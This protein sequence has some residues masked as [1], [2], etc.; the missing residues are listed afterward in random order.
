MLL[1]MTGGASAQ[2]AGSNS[3]TIGGVDVDATGPDAIQARQ[4]AIRQAQQKAVKLL[5]ERMVAPEDRA[6]VPPLDPARVDGMIR[7]VEFANERSSA[8]RYVGTLNVV[9]SAE[10]VNAWLREGGLLEVSAAP[11]QDAAIE[12]ALATARELGADDEAVAVEGD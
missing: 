8:N 3:Y 7:G 5:I 6:K 11:A 1:A 2:V 12:H 9:F 4:Q 10:P